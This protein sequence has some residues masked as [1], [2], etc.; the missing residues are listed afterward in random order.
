MDCQYLKSLAAPYVH[1]GVRFIPLGGLNQQN[2]GAYLADPLVLA[3][4]GSWLAP[5]HLIQNGDWLAIRENAAA[6]REQV[7]QLRGQGDQ[8]LKGSTVKIVTYGEIMARLAAPGFLRLR[9]A[10]PGSLDVTFA[11]AEANVAVSLSL[12]GARAE[13]VTALPHHVMA[14][15][16][17][18]VLRGLGVETA[19][20]RPHRCRST[21][22]LLPGKWGQSTSQPGHL[23]PGS[24]PRSA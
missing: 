11:G 17:L 15:A 24:I 8:Q 13:F 14:D 3:V 16:C 7:D 18:G 12:L 10:L 22:S 2:L 4:G 20:H 23:R 6:V 9:Q 19:S 21:G 1:L 5:R